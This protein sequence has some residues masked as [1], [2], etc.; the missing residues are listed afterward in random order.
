MGR[1][2]KVLS[3]LGDRYLDGRGSTSLALRVLSSSLHGTTNDKK[4]MGKCIVPACAL[5]EAALSF[6][7]CATQTFQVGGAFAWLHASFLH[8]SEV[9]QSEGRKARVAR[10]STLFLA[11]L[12]RFRIHLSVTSRVWFHF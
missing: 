2:C 10:T 3:E 5:H 4:N 9:K 1:M 8:S 6:L 11:L 7:A 12:T